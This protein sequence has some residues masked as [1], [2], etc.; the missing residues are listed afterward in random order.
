VS[1]MGNDYYSGRTFG[2]SNNDL[3]ALS[4]W[5][6]AQEYYSTDLKEFLEDLDRSDIKQIRR[7]T[8]ISRLK[9]RLSE[10]ESRDI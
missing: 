10:L 9:K 5:L 8:I 7:K 2:F 4:K 1:L 3:L 6:I